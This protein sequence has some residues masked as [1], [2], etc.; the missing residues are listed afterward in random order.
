MGRQMKAAKFMTKVVQVILLAV[1]FTVM[2]SAQTTASVDYVVVRPVVN[3][4]KA[5]SIDTEVVSQS[6]YGTNVKVL[7]TQGE[8]LEI[9]TADEYTGWVQS[10]GLRK[11]NGKPYTEGARIVRVSESSAN[12]YR[13]PD[14]TLHAPLLNLPWE[15]R[16][17]VINDKVDER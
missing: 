15:V 9:R 4:F 13:E 7:K 10:A 11:L 17:E 3:M 5:P 8:W 12:V 16:L 14:V 2:S 1:L 6:L